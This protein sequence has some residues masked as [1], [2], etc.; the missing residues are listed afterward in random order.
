MPEMGVEEHR[1][2]GTPAE[3]MAEH[4][5]GEHVWATELE[6]LRR[7][8]CNFLAAN[9]SRLVLLAKSFMDMSSLS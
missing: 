1:E 6:A 4:G 3:S 5:Q 8:K 9:Q 7:P 2:E